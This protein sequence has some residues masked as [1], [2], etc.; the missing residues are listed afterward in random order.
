VWLPDGRD[1]AGASLSVGDLVAVYESRSGRTRI[2]QCPDGSTLRQPCGRGREGVIYYGRVA[3]PLHSV[4]ESEPETYADG[5]VVWWRW[6]A[7]LDVLSQSG[8]VPRAA[9]LKIL[10]L[11]PTYNL[12]GFGTLHSG[13]LEIQKRQFDSIISKFR[14]SRPLE[15]TSFPIPRGRA[16]AGGTGESEEHRRLKRY[17]AKHPVRALRETGLKTLRVEY[18]FPTGDRA[19]IVLADA[20]ERVVAIEVETRV[21]ATEVIG[22]LQAIKYR[23]MLECVTDREP[24]D[25]RAILVAHRIAPEICDLCRKYAVEYVQIPEEEIKSK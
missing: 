1:A 20:F 16:Q 24:G 18:A 9:L 6:S 25:S 3:E 8:F 23:F 11:K 7:R 17:V 14:A 21:E 12:R 19:D 22:L 10:G 15:L 13:L 5:S 4:P 2:V